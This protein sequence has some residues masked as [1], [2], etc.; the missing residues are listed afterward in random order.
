MFTPAYPIRTERLSLRPFRMTDLDAV[1]A[2]QSREDVT[3]YLYWGP[4][5]RAEVREALAQRVN[6][7]RMD[8]F[9]DALA[10]AVELRASGELIGTA[11]LGWASVEHG[12]GE[13]GY[14]LHPDHHGRGYATE[15]AIAL[16]RLGF[17]QI[18]M[19]RVCGRC[20][21]RNTASARVLAKA[22]MRLEAHLR[23]NEFVKG[24]WTDELVYAMLA[25]EW[26]SR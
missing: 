5:S 11:N 24:E 15:I 12:Q 17:E 7:R 10:M 9:N 26:H 20:D 4:R 18:G 8:E 25:K 13:L 22:G 23:E 1:Y 6:Q 16:L 2:I 19:H 21:G 14:V 3:R